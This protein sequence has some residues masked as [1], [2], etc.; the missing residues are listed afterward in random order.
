MTGMYQ[1][2]DIVSQG[3]INLGTRA[4]TTLVRGHVVSGRPVTPPNVHMY[5]LW[6]RIVP[7]IHMYCTYYVHTRKSLVYFYDMQNLML[8]KY[9]M[10]GSCFLDIYRTE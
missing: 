9:E 3:T 5:I 7:T 4:P 8:L 2:R 1:S 6:Y 10:L